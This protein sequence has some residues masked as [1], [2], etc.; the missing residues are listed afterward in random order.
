M[1]LRGKT[2]H[3]LKWSLADSIGQQS[4]QFI[5]A[6][7]LARLLLPEEFG[8][9]GMLAVFMAVADV[10]VNG[11]FGMALVQMKHVEVEDA[12]AVFCVNLGMGCLMTVMLWCC[13]PGIAGFYHQPALCALMRLLSLLFIINAFGVVQTAL[14]SKQLDF[15]RQAMASLFSLVLSGGV[16][17][18]LALLGYGVWSIAWQM[19][20]A[21]G[22]RVGFLWV[23]SPWHPRL[24]FGLH[25]IR[26]LFTYGWKVV[27]S[28]LLDAV[29]NNVYLVVIGRVFTAAELGFYTRAQ[30]FQTLPLSTISAVV[31]RVLF[32]AF[33]HIQ[34]DPERLRRATREAVQALMLVTLPLMVGLA[35]V[36]EPIVEV[37]LTRRWLPCAPLLSI[38]C[39]DG[40]LY[41]LHALNW[42]VVMVMGH[43]DLYL[44][45]QIIKRI[46]TAIAV[47]L[48]WKWGLLAMVWGQVVVSV[49]SIFVNSY[50]TTKLVRYSAFTQIKDV[51]G[52][53]P[54]AVVLG[55]SLFVA[56][57]Y[58]PN[59]AWSQLIGQAAVGVVVY[60]LYLVMFHR[61]QVI[62]L[63]GA[64]RKV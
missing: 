48:T 63:I 38:L 10:L 1:T 20:V 30:R 25:R 29:F 6:L 57:Q 21:S 45:L 58:L 14:L 28:G 5:V 36:A 18:G 3:A 26:R 54:L 11:G 56:G 37:L 24:V 43:S 42:N 23:V 7:I 31:S 47:S 33:A 19:I 39:I 17:I 46:L 61:S 15:K 8:L 32:P 44:R 22:S 27:A 49:L 2:V 62:A 35:L 64:M 50:Y 41:P 16:G 4:L 51:C 12:S 52:V 13:A 55:L 60:G 53:L 9:I 40:A 34:D 59:D